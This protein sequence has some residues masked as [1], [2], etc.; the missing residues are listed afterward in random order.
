ME[1]ARRFIEAVSGFLGS[2]IYAGRSPKQ[3]S[4]RKFAPTVRLVISTEV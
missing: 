3:F 2:E 1:L 4:R